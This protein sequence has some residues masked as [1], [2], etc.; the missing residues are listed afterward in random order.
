MKAH[1]LNSASEALKQ[2]FAQQ[3][4]PIREFGVLLSLSFILFYFFWTKVY[5]QPYESLSLRL[6][7]ILLGLLLWLTPFWPKIFQRF[8]VWFWFT[9]LLYSLGFFFAYY[10]LRNEGTVISAMSLLCSIFLLVLLV[11]SWMFVILMGLGWSL[12][13][14]CY[15]MTVPEMYFGEEH[16]EM[17]MIFVFIIISGIVVSY[18]QRFFYQMR[19]DGMTAAASMIAHELRTPLLSIRVGSDVLHEHLPHL[20]DAYEKAEQAQLIAPIGRRARFKQL[21]PI[22]TRIRREVD[23]ANTMIDMLLNNAANEN[24]WHELVLGECSIHAILEEAIQR[25]PFKSPEEKLSVQ[26]QGDFIF[27]GH[28]LLI[29]HVVF[30]LLKNALYMIRREG[31]GCISIWVEQGEKDN[32]LCFKDTAGGMSEKELSQLFRHFYSKTLSGTGLGLS[33]CK[34]VMRHLGGDI[35]CQAKSGEFTLFRMRFPIYFKH[36]MV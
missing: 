10:F 26:F 17:T 15:A 12:A 23:Y 8:Q 1:F 6:V 18:K 24:Q 4:L 21:H 5:E 7:G 36:A 3:L 14:L 13:G 30:N 33:F 20:L 34:K 29:E 31:R 16:I 25:Y 19:L 32:I 35:E 22:T 27:L 2:R 11:D 28:P 9:T